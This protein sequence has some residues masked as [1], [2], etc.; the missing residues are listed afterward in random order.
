MWVWEMVVSG[1]GF[2]VC[3]GFFGSEMRRSKLFLVFVLG[4]IVGNDLQ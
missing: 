2:G 4:A 1:F 3:F